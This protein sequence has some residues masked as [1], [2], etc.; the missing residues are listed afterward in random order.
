MRHL[1]RNTKFGRNGE[2]RNAMLTNLAAS[3]IKHR[4]VTTTV[5][6]AKV[7]RQVI[8]KLITL[9]RHAIGASPARNVHLRRLAAG[10]LRQQPRS[11]FRG[12]PTVR[13]KVAREAWREQNDVVHILF[14][15]IAP[16]FKDRSGGYTRIVKLG[17]RQGDSAQLA[18]IELVEAPTV[19]PAATVVTDAAAPAS[20]S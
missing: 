16:Q 1:K 12:T 17:Q 19:A 6:K 7:V 4:R 5:T 14:D 9:G 15:K 10:R 3:I 13:G 8:E 11:L 2:H 20:G 18:I